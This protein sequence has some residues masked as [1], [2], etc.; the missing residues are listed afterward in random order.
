MNSERP[1]PVKKVCIIVSKGSLDGVYPALIMAN[2][3]RMEGI[4][5]SL[6]FTFFGLN[7]LNKTTLDHLKV[8]TVG[9]SALNMAMPMLGMPMTMPF[10]TVVGAIPG[11]SN[12]AT[13][14]MNKE[15]EK[16]DIPP[17]REFLEL[18]SD[19][20]GKIFACKLAMD[21]FKLKKEDL[22]DGVEDVLTVGQF[23]EDAAG[24]GTQIIFT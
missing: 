19:S 3:A 4:E 13:H 9:N 7:A 18:I 8:S 12:F 22:W 10:P 24:E 6:F 20:G 1:A 11:V 2:G 14:L 15:M 5:A 23:Y 16:L 21:M 17:V